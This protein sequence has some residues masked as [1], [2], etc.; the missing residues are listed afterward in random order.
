M[1]RP[2]CQRRPA[3]TPPA[4]SPLTA[5][6]GA[7]QAGA[8]RRQL[9]CARVAVPVGHVHLSPGQGGFPRAGPRPLGCRA[10][11]HPYR[12]PAEERP[13]AASRPDPQVLGSA[14]ALDP[15]D[16]TTGW[17]CARMAGA[18]RSSHRRC[19]IG[20]LTPGQF[21]FSTEGFAKPTKLQAPL[22]LT[23]HPQNPLSEAEV[24]ARASGSR[25]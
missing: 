11:R 20:K 25:R 4:T 2:C 9:P 10:R 5:S 3:T 19:D 16:A 17:L 12:E 7:R 21:Y 1:A 14:A 23:H 18:W 15:A 13:A 8:R 22:C 6:F 24:I